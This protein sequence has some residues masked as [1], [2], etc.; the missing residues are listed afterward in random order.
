KGITRFRHK[1]FPKLENSY[2][3][4]LRYALEGR[5]SWYFLFGTF[6]LLIFSFVLVGIVQPNVLFFPDNEPNQVITYIEYPEGT[7]IEK[8]NELTK[9]I[10]KRIAR[11]I[12]KYEDEDGYNFMVESMIS[13]VGQGA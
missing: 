12:E 6:G 4:F 8:T 1:S 5:K 3:R 10:E 9:K 7:A 13:Q 2:E 11:A